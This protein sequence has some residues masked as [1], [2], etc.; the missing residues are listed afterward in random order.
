VQVVAAVCA[1]AVLTAATARA[2][3]PSG[4]G[5]RLVEAPALKG[6]TAV[7]STNW[8]GYAVTSPDPAVPISFTSV[9]GTWK[10]TVATCG[11]KDDHS[12]SSVWV[13]LGG[14]SLQ[15]QALEQIG[16]SGD[17]SPSGPP[18]YYA[19][20]ELV[21][22]P[23]VSF[24]LKIKPGDVITTSVNVSGKTITLQL[25][26]RTRGT[27][28]TKRATVASQ[29]IS[30][31]EWIA[32]APSS[33]NT[34]TCLPVPLVNF[35]AVKFSRAAT[36]GNGHSG[37]ITDPSWSPDAIQLVPGTQ[38]GFSP[39]PGAGFGNPSSTAGTCP[40][41][42]LSGDGRSFLISWTSIAAVGS[43]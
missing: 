11:Q 37:T 7:S 2:G 41:A 22:D 13:G 33:C 29:D 10:Q 39:S 5:L 9:T 6:S 28:A 8:S 30:S 27:V 17:C 23:P 32:E 15:S 21:P 35:G 1:L 19:W 40:P 12:A 20:Y 31:A 25:K 26:D 36:I 24:A 14:F 34:S 42:G 18:S 43:C 3:G 38:P 16:T 4:P